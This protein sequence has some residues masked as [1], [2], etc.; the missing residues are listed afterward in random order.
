MPLDWGWCGA[1]MFF[2]SSRRR[3]TRLQG[4]WSSDVCSSDLYDWTFSPSNTGAAGGIL[5]FSGADPAI[6]AD[7]GQN[8]AS[9]TAHATPSVT[10]ALPNTMIITSHGVGAASSTWTPPAGMTESVDA[11]GGSAAVEM[12]YVLQGT[13]GASGAKSATATVAGTGNA[14]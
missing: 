7:G 11:T 3:H 4:D 12:N 5:A 9:G 8:T 2:F 13:A 6:E 1:G 14:H 10:T